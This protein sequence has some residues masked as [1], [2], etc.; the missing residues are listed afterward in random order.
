MIFPRAVHRFRKA[1]HTTRTR[2][3][4]TNNTMTL[5]HVQIGAIVASFVGAVIIIACVVLPLTKKPNCFTMSRRGRHPVDLPLR[6]LDIE[7]QSSKLKTPAKQPSILAHI[8]RRPP[9]SPSSVNRNLPA[10]PKT[11]S[12]NISRPN[13]QTSSGQATVTMTEEEESIAEIDD[14][15]NS[16]RDMSIALTMRKQEREETRRA[17]ARDTLL[18]KQER[19]AQENSQSSEQRE[20]SAAVRGQINTNTLQRASV[21]EDKDF[22]EHREYRDSMEVKDVFV[23]GDDVSLSSDKEERERDIVVDPMAFPVGSGRVM[24][25]LYGPK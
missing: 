22:I 20:K 25:A 18:R 13:S 15:R 24:A 12:L 23:V 6:S 9:A 3:I 14:E 10:A 2:N 4:P 11:V 1:H 21:V 16:I 7:A 19:E 8:F 17:I 5:T